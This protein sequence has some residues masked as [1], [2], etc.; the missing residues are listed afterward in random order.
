VSILDT[1]FVLAHLDRVIEDAAI[2]ELPGHYR[3]KVRD[4]YNLGD[5]RRLLVTSDRLS[6]FDRALCA[7]PFK[8]QVLTQMARFWF[9]A[10]S[11][12][13]ANHVISFPDPNVTLCHDLHMLPIEVVVRGFL[14]GTTG[15]SVLTRYAAGERR[16]YGLDFPDGMIAN[17]A[18]PA[19]IVTPTS[20]GDATGHDEPL[21]SAK[22]V[23]RGLVPAKLWDEVCTTALA[24]F[25]RGQEIARARGLIL[26]DTK[27]EFGLDSDG[28][29]VLADEIH[30][31][32][33]SR[34]WLAHSY[35]DHVSRQMSPESLDKDVVRNWLASR[36]DPYG[37][38][39]PSILA[40][41]IAQTAIAYIG[42]FECLSGVPFQPDLAGATVLD[43]IRSRLLPLFA[44]I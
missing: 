40:D 12:I 32:D 2:R 7:V 3:G 25:A 5:G 31:L 14:A 11:D 39:I 6:A 42:A 41:L 26:V 38:A 19:A 33:S 36:C 37:D 18:L 28:R 34:Y 44:A 35:D 23:E 21:S 43:R 16:I 4:T 22:I 8:G 9:D 15:T 17:Q 30:T 24:L 27:Y 13:C 1:S 20:K 10:T 29:L